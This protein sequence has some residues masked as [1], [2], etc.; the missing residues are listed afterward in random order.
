V[1]AVCERARSEGVHTALA[2]AMFY[3]E[4]VMRDICRYTDGIAAAL[5]G[6]SDLFYHKVVGTRDPADGHND[7]GAVLKA[8]EVARECGT[9]M[10]ITNLIVPTYNDDL[11]EIAAMAAWIAKNLGEE[12]PLHF[13]R[14]VPEFKL[15]NLPPTPIQT[16][17][18][19]RKAAQDAGLKFVYCSNVAPHEGNNTY[20]P[21]CDAVL[22]QRVG[23]KI[24]ENRLKD[25]RCPAC[26]TAIPGFYGKT[27]GGK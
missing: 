13:G 16:L 27:A 26:G 1:K 19:A 4:H 3:N 6:W 25:G 24:L 15:K 23:F 20:C 8:L 2:S 12:V 7:F 9:W 21:S 11:K 18:D 10:E 22:V 5:K 14:F 17:T